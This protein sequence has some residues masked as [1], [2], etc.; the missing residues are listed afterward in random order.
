M[1][2]EV[3][4]RTGHRKK[5]GE[6]G[7]EMKRLLQNTQIIAFT[8]ML[9]LA[10][11]SNVKAAVPTSGLVAYYPFNS[12]AN[13]ESGNGNNGTV[14]GATLT[15]DRNGNTNSAYSFDGL[16]DY[17]QIPS[18]A[19]N[20]LPIG[21]YCTWVKI[22]QLNKQ[23][24]LGDKTETWVANYFQAIVDTNNKI[25]WYI[26]SIVPSISGGP[27]YSS[28]TI[29]KDAWYFICI[30]WDG[31][32][33]KVYV[34][35]ALDAT[36]TTS[37]GIPSVNRNTFLGKVDNNAALLDGFLDDIRI[38]NRALSASEIQTLNNEGGSTTTTCKN[39]AY[40]MTVGGHEAALMDVSSITM[41]PSSPHPGEKVSV[42]VQWNTHGGTNIVKAIAFGNWNTNT[43]SQVAQFYDDIDG[44]G[45]KSA[46]FSFYLPTSAGSYSLR[47][48][49]AYDAFGYSNYD[50]SNMP[51]SQQCSTWG[52]SYTPYLDYSF[53]LSNGNSSTTT[54][55]SGAKTTTTT[56]IS[57]SST[58]TTVSETST[59][60][61]T[62][63]NS[64]TTTTVSNG[65]ITTTVPK[66]STTTTSATGSETGEL[67]GPCYGNGSCNTGLVCKNDICAQETL[68]EGVEGGP[69]YGN[70]TCN[71]GLICENNICVE[72]PE[73]ECGSDQSCQGCCITSLSP[74][75][76]YT[77]DVEAFFMLRVS[78]CR[79]SLLELLFS[80]VS[81]AG[82]GGTSDVTAPTALAINDLVFGVMEIN[83]KAEK[84][85]YDVT[86]KTPLKEASGYKISVK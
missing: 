2:T 14:N 62:I 55:V 83:S 75:S 71:D 77:T 32:T 69:C 42:T 8:A 12:N 82:P 33:H 35:G 1:G 10:L 45:S 11:S 22:N 26:G 40:K 60:T 31:T 64:S 78:G 37:A 41:N 59:T 48:I 7:K 3:N 74:D 29:N 44:S 84:G 34:N 65:S 56:T 15:T 47:L 66:A 58:T 23:H 17:I 16:N 76:V 63:S 57:G 36:I 9:F 30:T 39:I 25:R 50:M 49:W 70:G 19:L 54:T 13:D 18:S 85:C 21:S 20:N 68:E 5:N 72:T 6:G 86:V 52:N 38:Y 53:T 51:T 73:I 61:T 46:T 28:S 43:G 80:K 4:R 79:F 24:T 81:F 67:G 27:F